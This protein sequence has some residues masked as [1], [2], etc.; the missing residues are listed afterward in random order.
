MVGDIETLGLAGGGRQIAAA[1]AK[2]SSLLDGLVK[3]GSLQ[4]A[5]LTLD[6]A[7]KLTNR[8]VNA[9]DNVVIPRLTNTVDYIV[10][11]LDEIE[12]EEFFRLKKVLKVKE[13]KNKEE[14]EVRTRCSL[15]FDLFRCILRLPVLASS[16]VTSLF[17]H[18]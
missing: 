14:E 17:R 6:E 2:F 16:F 10:S 15:W 9:L 3:L 1:K 8:R 13:R 18:S 5:F 7:I 11:E 12:K 4:T